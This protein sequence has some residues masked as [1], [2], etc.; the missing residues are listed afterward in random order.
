MISGGIER[1]FQLTVPQNYDGKKPF[2]ILLELHALSISNTFVSG[3]TG[4]PT[5]HPV[6]AS[7]GSRR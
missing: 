7:S 3:M 2:P 4:S 1:K 6:T 5:W